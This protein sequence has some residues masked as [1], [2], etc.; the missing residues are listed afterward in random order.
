VIKLTSPHISLGQ[1]PNFSQITV[2]MFDKNVSSNSPGK[3]VDE[4]GVWGLTTNTTLPPTGFFT[5]CKLDTTVDNSSYSRSEGNSV[6]QAPQVDVEDDL[7]Q[8]RK[9]LML[10]TELESAPPILQQLEPEQLQQLMS[11]LRQQQPS[12]KM[13]VSQ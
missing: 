11:L 13:V 4:V 5:G 7:Q 9:L 12:I 10:E 1:V 2:D 3:I 6:K 8:W